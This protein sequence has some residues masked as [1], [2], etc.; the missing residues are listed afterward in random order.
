MAS[1]IDLT[2]TDPFTSF[3]PGA[4]Y[5]TIIKQRLASPISEK[6]C[7]IVAKVTTGDLTRIMVIIHI[8]EKICNMMVIDYRPIRTPNNEND[9][10]QRTTDMVEV[11]IYI[12]SCDPS[13]GYHNSFLLKSNVVISDITPPVH[14]FLGL[15]PGIEYRSRRRLVDH[16]LRHTKSSLTYDPDCWNCQL[17]IV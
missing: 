14:R 15:K 4:K 8:G 6:E 7:G 11:H 13:P 5:T 17:P 16:V 2:A 12:L 1:Y 3:L 9:D 10:P